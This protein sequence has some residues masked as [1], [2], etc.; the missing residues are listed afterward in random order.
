MSTGNLNA[1]RKVAFWEGVSTL[2]LFGVAVPLKYLA[3]QPIYVTIFGNIHGFL[4][5]L[6]LIFMVMV[7]IKYKWNAILYV[8]CLLGA[9]IPFGA[10]VVDSKFLKPLSQK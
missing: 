7:G 3:D 9:V 10:F 2:I 5:L 6:Y 4:F 1:F 8:M